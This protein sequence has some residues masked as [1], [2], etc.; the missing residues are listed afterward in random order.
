MSPHFFFFFL[1]C[2][3]A[4]FVFLTLA[5]FDNVGAEFVQLKIYDY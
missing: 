4:Y 2:V 3:L 5:T 1:N